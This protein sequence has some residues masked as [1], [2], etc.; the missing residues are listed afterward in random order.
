[1]S[2]ISQQYLADR[3]GVSFQQLQKYETG[4]NRIGSSRLQMIADALG[5]SPA[6]FFEEDNV[7]SSSTDSVTTLRYSKKFTHFLSTKEAMGLNRAYAK[8]TDPIRRHAVLVLIQ[9]L[10]AKSGCDTTIEE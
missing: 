2:G 6:F 7:E 8:I 9:T 4:R 5:V 1:M 3:I 10:A